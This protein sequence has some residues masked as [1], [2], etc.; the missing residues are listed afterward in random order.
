M[1][2]YT[3]SEWVAARRDCKQLSPLGVAAADFLGDVY[4][5]IYHINARALAK[6][7]WSAKDCVDITLGDDLA[8][9]DS[10]MLTRMVVLAH[11]RMLRVEIRGIGPG[12]LR[13]RISQRATRD[14][15]ASVYERHPSLEDHAALLRA[16]YGDARTKV[17]P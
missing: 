9:Y 13:L 12:Y 1:N 17:Q 10:D 16:H 4:L 5:G 11:D 8:T 3:G 7:D 15:K 2:V 6:V 14:P